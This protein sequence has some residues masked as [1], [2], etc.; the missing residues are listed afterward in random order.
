MLHGVFS[1]FRLDDPFR[2]KLRS[3]LCKDLRAI[4]SW[5]DVLLVAQDQQAQYPSH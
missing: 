4:S 1:V 3:N 5:E 2:I